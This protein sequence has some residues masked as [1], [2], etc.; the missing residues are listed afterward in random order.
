LSAQFQ[1]NCLGAWSL[2]QP[3]LAQAIGQSLLNVELHQPLLGNKSSRRKIRQQPNH[4]GCA[5]ISTTYA[6]LR[7]CLPA[8][9]DVGAVRYIDYANDRLPTMNMFE[10]IMHKD[11]YYGFE[12]EVRAVAFPPAAGLELAD[13][14][15]NRF[16]V[17]S[18]PGFHVFAPRVDS[19]ALIEGVVLHPEASSAF[20]ADITALCISKGLSR[21]KRSRKNQS[22]AF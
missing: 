8:Y 18:N 11:S 20:E 22:P 17:E 3:R 6:A 2:R 5:S 14:R 19:V 9:V 13:F 16:E 1:L 15:A 10:Y 12:C 4:I 7:R 21:P